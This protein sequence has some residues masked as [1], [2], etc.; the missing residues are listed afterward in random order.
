MSYHVVGL[1]TKNGQAFPKEIHKKVR[2]LCYLF[3]GE[4]DWRLYPNQIYFD[5]RGSAYDII[6]ALDWELEHN[7]VTRNMVDFYKWACEH[8]EVYANCH[9]PCDFE[10][11][12]NSMEELIWMV[13][14][15]VKIAKDWKGPVESAWD[16]DIKVMFLQPDYETHMLGIQLDEFIFE[17]EIPKEIPYMWVTDIQEGVLEC[18]YEECGRKVVYIDLANHPQVLALEETDRQHFLDMLMKL[19]PYYL[20]TD[21]YRGV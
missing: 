4:V 17:V 2:E 12:P 15:A 8:C 6:S 19:E 20:V 11:G 18:R 1:R 10:E 9:N 16:L 7:H 13:D 3:L 14:M 21:H 5:Y